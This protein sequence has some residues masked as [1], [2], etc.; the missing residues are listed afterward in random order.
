MKTI[1]KY[2]LDVSGGTNL[3]TALLPKDAVVL[4]V[5]LQNAQLFVWAIVDDQQKETE[6]HLFIVSGTGHPLPPV[7][8][9]RTMVHI[10]TKLY[11]DGALVLHAF[12]LVKGQEA[13]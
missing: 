1:Y 5:G 3:M 12:E 13:S 4:D 8:E 9:D 11:R 2:P 10:G 7:P 6:G